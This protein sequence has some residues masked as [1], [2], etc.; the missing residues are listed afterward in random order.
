MYDRKMKGLAALE[1]EPVVYSEMIAEVKR[2]NDAF[3][4]ET[5]KL[6]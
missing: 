6:K 2:K 5:K 3:N 1:L 4:L